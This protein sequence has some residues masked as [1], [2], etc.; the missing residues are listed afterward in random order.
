MGIGYAGPEWEWPIM[1]V[2]F[3]LTSHILQQ[4]AHCDR[5]TH[6]GCRSLQKDSLAGVGEGRDGGCSALVSQRMCA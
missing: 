6:E 5:Q 4:T 2:H 1:A 3:I